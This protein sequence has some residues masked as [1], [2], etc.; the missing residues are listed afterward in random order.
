MM[1]SSGKLACCVLGVSLVHALPAFL[2]L[3]I[4]SRSDLLESYDYVVVGA[5][6]SGLTVAN[7]LSED[8]G[9]T[10]L[11]RHAFMFGY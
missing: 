1:F 11:A 10:D 8:V 2:G 3:V 5:G 4:D 6:A 7:R 9:K